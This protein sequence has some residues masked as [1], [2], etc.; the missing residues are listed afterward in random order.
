MQKSTQNQDSTSP[1][2]LINQNNQHSNAAGA[3]EK[4]L[5]PSEIITANKQNSSGT[6]IGSEDF[7]TELSQ[8]ELTLLDYKNKFIDNIKWSL[9]HDDIIYK[10]QEHIE[11]IN[12]QQHSFLD[13]AATIKNFKHQVMEILQDDVNSMSAA[14]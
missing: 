1:D 13:Q 14:Y 8:L 6:D 12:L 10:K 11:L 7:L 3:D 5:P 4:A 2:S 9:L